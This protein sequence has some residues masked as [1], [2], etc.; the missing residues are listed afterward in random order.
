MYQ[1]I[2]RKYRPQSFA[3]LVNQ[4]HIK[5][6]LSNAI[7]QHRIAHGYIFSGQRGTGKTTVARI[8]A[9]CLNCLEGPTMSPCG[10]CSSCIEVSAGNSVDV[11]EIDAASNRGINEMRELRESVRFRPAR[12]RYK[13]FIIDEAHQITNDAFNALLKTLEEPPEWVVFMLCTTEAH[14]L[15]ATISSRCQHFSFRSVEMDELI[16]RMQWICGQEGIEADA[17]ALAVLAQAGGGS[18]RDSLSALD[19]AIACCGNIL[20][21]EQVRFLMGAYSLDTLEKVTAALESENGQTML[22]LVD[23][24]ER[25]GQNLQHFCREISAYFRNLLVAKVAGENPR[26]I[27]ASRSEVERLAQISERFSERDLTRY[28]NIMLDVFG[29]LQHSLQPRFHLELGLM[30]LIHAGR[31]STVEQALTELRRGGG[32]GPGGGSGGPKS[33]GSS[34][35]TTSVPSAG[36]ASAG[37]ATSGRSPGSGSPSAS[38]APSRPQAT[39]FRGI[40]S[41]LAAAPASTPRVGVSPAALSQPAASP[42]SAIEEHADVEEAAGRE[43]APE[44]ARASHRLSVHPGGRDGVPTVGEPKFPLQSTPLPSTPMPSS[45]EVAPIADTS[46]PSDANELQESLIAVLNKT[47]KRFTADAMERA[48]LSLATLP[49][50]GTELTILAPRDTSLSVKEAELREALKA[51]G[52]GVQRLKLEFGDV[53]EAASPRAQRSSADAEAL[54]GEVEADPDVQY[55]RELFHGTITRVRSLRS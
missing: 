42:Q 32:D 52:I 37:P 55:I 17:D 34:T 38:A 3:D 4:E 14:K 30:R 39:S 5:R 51:A 27:S 10:K 24:L 48:R 20:N 54:R 9:R 22:E 50:G 29:Q 44:P 7:E 23:E 25:S 19:Q 11:I 53:E 43:A 12:D 13:V 33:G 28:L 16:A 41:N 40:P 18:V 8:M 35:N 21:A 15:P 26:L 1:V 46:A 36:S 31:L 2:A 49:S 47:G 6:T 45:G